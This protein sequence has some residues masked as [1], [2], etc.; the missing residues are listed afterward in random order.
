MDFNLSEEQVYL[1]KA[2]SD[3]ALNELNRDLE[4]REKRNEFPQDL[5]RKCAAMGIMSLP[6]GPQFGGGGLDFLSTTVAMEALSYSCKDSGLVHAI[7]TQLISGLL[8]NLFGSKEQ[9]ERFLPKI[10]KGEIIAAQAITEAD[11]GSDALSMRTKAVK[12][13]NQY[14]LD[15]RKMF[16]TNGPIADVVLVLAVTNPDRKAMGGH[17]FFI[18]EK[19]REGFIRGNPFE[20]LGLRTLQNCELIF[21]SCTLPPHN[22]I[23]QEGQGA[24]IFNEMMEWE[25]IL[26]G[27]CH[28]GIL[29]RIIDACVRYAKERCQFGQPIG[30]F[31]S[32]GNKIARMKINY[33]LLRPYIYLAAA[34]KDAKKRSAMEASVIKVFASESLKSACLDA[35]QIHGAYGYM[36]EYEIERDLRDS[37][38]STIYSGTTELNVVIITRLLGL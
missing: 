3:F 27:A 13:D 31:Q 25:R 16:I 17:S 5:W 15:G 29:K 8:L 4:S 36:V 20:K 32:V 21:D 2:I 22:L 35:V 38:A 19:E 6:F 30:K 11:S 9:K 37:I 33:E 12:S 26:F 28:L 34:N 14:I 1:Q 18:C 7:S 23:G 24:I 10:C